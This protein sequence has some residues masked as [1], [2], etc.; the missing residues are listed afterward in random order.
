MKDR[1]Y[2]ALIKKQ[3]LGGL[4]L[5]LRTRCKAMRNTYPV[6]YGHQIL[7]YESIIKHLMELQRYRVSMSKA[8]EMSDIRSDS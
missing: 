5:N 3:E 7:L 2:K 1:D 4:I 6:E 8:E